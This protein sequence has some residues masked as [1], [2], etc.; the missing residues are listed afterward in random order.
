MLSFAG[1]YW[2]GDERN[3]QLQRVYGTAFPSQ[4]ELDEHLARLEEAKRRDHRTLGK[5][6]GPVLVRRA[7]RP[8]LRALAPEGR[9]SSA[10]R[11]RT[12]SGARTCAAATSSVYTPHVAREQLLET[13][14]H[15]AHYKENLFGG[16]E[17]DGQRYLVKPMNCPFHIAIYRSQLR[18]YRELPLR[19]SELG[20]V[21]RYERS[22]V[23]HGLLRVRGADPGRRATS[24]CARTRSSDEIARLRDVRARDAASCSASRTFDLFLATRPGELHGRA[25]GLGAGRGGAARACSRRPAGRSRSTRAAGAFYG[26][27]IDLKIRDALGR[28]WQCSTFQLDFQ[29]PERFELEYVGAGRQAAS[30]RS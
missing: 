26:P 8:G 28:E 13:S 14:G 4:E 16:M 1:A 6:A 29:L 17:L 27:K 20:T 5:R 3:P 30:G 12:S 7:G 23:L 24:S 19:Y 18:S 22:G 11:S 9:A 2:R 15:L 21:Y 25:G 10:T